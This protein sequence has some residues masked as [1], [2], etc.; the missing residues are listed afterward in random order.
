MSVRSKRAFISLGGRFS[1]MAYSPGDG[2]YV[3]AG[4]LSG[5]CSSPGCPEVEA[6]EGYVLDG[7]H[8]RIKFPFQ[9]VDEPPEIFQ[10][11][12]VEAQLNG[13]GWNDVLSAVRVNSCTW[14]FE[15]DFTINVGDT[16]DWRNING[17]PESYGMTVC[18]QSLT[19]SDRE[20]LDG[21]GTISIDPAVVMISYAS[22]ETTEA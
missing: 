5:Y 8:I 16:V 18:D 20:P 10:W 15:V 17:Y 4:R 1:G 3:Q 2:R 21:S 22:F 12:S 11:A 9:G 19:E 14:D 13:G 7:T 6:Y